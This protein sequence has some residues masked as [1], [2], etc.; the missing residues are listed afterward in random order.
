[1]YVQDV[2]QPHS[3]LSIRSNE[4]IVNPQ[5]AEAPDI[6]AD[7][8]TES[9]ADR[10]ISA[11]ENSKTGILKSVRN[12]EY[13]AAVN[14]G[15]MEAAQK[16]VEAFAKTMGYRIHAYHGTGRADRVGTVFL[17]ER[18][19]SGPM[20]FFTD[21]K[22]IA[23]HYA[24]DKADTSLAYDEEYAD[25]YSQFRVNQNGKSVK[26]QDLWRSLPFAE[27][28]RLKEAGKHITWD[29]DMTN[30]VWDED[31]THG[32][33]NWDAYTLNLHKGN[34]IE[35]LIDCW[36]ESGELYGNEGDFLK[37]LEMAGIDGVEYRDP[38][39]R[40]EKVY[41]TYLNIQNPFDTANVDD[42]FAD[43]FEEWYENQPAGKYDRDTA[44]ADMWDKNSQTAESFLERLRDDIE[45]GTSYAWTS[46]PDSMTDYLKFLGHDGIMDTGGKNG[47]ETHTV[48]IPF[49]PE[50]IKSA[51]PVTYDNDGNIIPLS[52]RFNESKKDIRY[53]KRNELQKTFKNGQNAR[54]EFTANILIDL[55]DSKSDW[56]TGRYNRV[57]LGMSKTDD[58]EF[59]QFYQEILK[60]TKDMNEYAEADVKPV[61]DSFTIQDGWGKEFIYVVELDGYLHGT[62]LAKV[63]KAKYAAAFL[64]QTKGG[65]NGK[66]V[67]N[68][69]RRTRAARSGIGRSNSGSSRYQTPDSNPGHGRLGSGSS[70]GN[71]T[72]NDAGESS[73]NQEVPT[74]TS[75]AQIL[76]SNRTTESLS[77]RSIL[78]N[79]LEGVAQN[80]WEQNKLN[81]YKEN[82][83]KVEE[84]ESRLQEINSQL[85]P[86]GKKMPQKERIALQDEAVGLRNKITNIDKKLLRLEATKPL[87]NVLNR[88]RARVRREMKQKAEERISEVKAEA[89]QRL[90]RRS[91]GHAA[92]EMRKKI[93]KTIRELDKILNRGDKKRN[94]KEDMKDRRYDRF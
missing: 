45:N 10:Y 2:R 41:D 52:D 36:L 39:A 93:R 76:T 88:E 11:D 86:Y 58:T 80:E 78:T 94:V 83:A 87:Q 82:I 70:D 79:A 62:V 13:L 5:F 43:G 8:K 3:I 89:A 61:E 7:A 85:Y 25:Y 38:D 73:A 55:S 26:V 12:E 53:S 92:T 50:Q 47:G 33:G 77:T 27:K 49:F 9:V 65:N 14:R 75:V 22:E 91:E 74:V 16:M 66:S 40:H 42:A 30:I 67:K 46:I 18:A 35:A 6:S 1:M 71:Q 48:W 31:A 44:A 24:R 19:T 28:Q 72:G 59:R 60:R 21:T 37:V 51:D 29:D 69:K 20:A 15:D 68:I 34:A 32:L 57:I 90:K 84:M 17:P 64:K 54:G 81:E 4:G 56:W 63:D 23:E